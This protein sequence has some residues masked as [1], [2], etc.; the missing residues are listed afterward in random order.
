MDVILC[1]SLEYLA[2]FVVKG[3][4]SKR[5]RSQR[6]KSELIIV[7][8]LSVNPSFLSL[9]HCSGACDSSPFLTQ[10]KIACCC[11]AF[12]VIFILFI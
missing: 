9:P 10:I 7:A 11:I 12:E 3:Q 1:R 8:M 4:V 6:E 2:K 5:K